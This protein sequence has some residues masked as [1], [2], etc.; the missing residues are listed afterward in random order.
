MPPTVRSGPFVALPTTGSTS[1]AT[2]VV[3]AYSEKVDFA[4]ST[5]KTTPGAT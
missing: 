2:G 4:R 5:L 1:P 3:P